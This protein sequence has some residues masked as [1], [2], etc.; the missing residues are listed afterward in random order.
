MQHVS[1]GM[2]KSVPNIQKKRE[3][4]GRY[5]K[6]AKSDRNKAKVR[7]DRINAK[8]A[9]AGRTDFIKRPYSRK[10]LQAA[11]DAAGPATM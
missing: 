10:A 7:R 3:R 1:K 2:Q 4:H 6:K 8:M 5:S 9:A 11:V